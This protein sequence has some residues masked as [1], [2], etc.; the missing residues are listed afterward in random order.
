MLGSIPAGSVASRAIG[1]VESATRGMDEGGN[2]PDPATERRRLVE[3]AGAQDGRGR[4]DIGE[5]V[6]P[7]PQH[8][9]RQR[10][11]RHRV[12]HR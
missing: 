9:L 7:L 11:P 4:G 6:V 10:P 3:T 2:R 12:E 1:L 5:H 8:Q